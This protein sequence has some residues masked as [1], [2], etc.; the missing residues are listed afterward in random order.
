MAAPTKTIWDLKPH[1]QAKH[2]ILKRYL[3]AWLP[4]LSHGRF[5]EILYIDGF[6]G[7]GRYSKGEDGSPIIALKEA[8]S[9]NLRSDTKINFLFIEKKRDRAECLEAIIRSRQ[10]PPNFT[11]ECECGAFEEIF[12]AYYEKRNRAL[13]ATFAFIDPFGWTGAP[14]RLTRQILDQRSCEVLFNFMSDEIGR[15]V[16]NEDQE[17][18]FDELFGA[19]DWRHCLDI[20]DVRDR[21]KC[22]HDLFIRQLRKSAGARFV[23]SFEM[24][25]RAN[26]TDYLLFYAT[27]NPKGLEKMKEAM[28]KA[29]ESGEFTF[30]DATDPKQMVM[31]AATP[32]YDVLEQQILKRLEG[33]KVSL[34]ELKRF[35]IEETA[36][37]SSHY[38]RQIL[39]P[40]EE[41]G[42]IRVVTREGEIP[43]DRRRNTFP[44]KRGWFLEFMP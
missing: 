15:F 1:T 42:S 18:N 22:L 43:T 29:D 19:T 26:K 23:R 38:K 27:N 30:S 9:A 8:A 21:R 40:L 14:F 6:A 31:F 4:I 39:Q 5:P 2:E 28:W 35:V 34:V 16:A 3:G 20:Q 13:P 25:N 7:P 37:L 12:S 11:I 36:F 24:K 10:W 44:E 32:K 17:R 41:R 33:H